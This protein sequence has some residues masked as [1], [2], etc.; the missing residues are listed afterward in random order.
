MLQLQKADEL[1]VVE[2]TEDLPEYDLRKGAQGTIVEVFDKPA[3]GYMVEFVE[4]E[5]SA[6]KIVDWLLP[7]QIENLDEKAVPF[8]KQGLEHLNHGDFLKA[9]DQFRG[10]F[11]LKPTLVRLLHN[12]ISRIAESEDWLRV[13][14]GMRFITELSPSY[15]LARWHL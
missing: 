10:A 2:L 5:G 11:E 8:F 7:S 4:G 13:A 12:M 14:R 3:E 6:S 1:D 9:A 15:E